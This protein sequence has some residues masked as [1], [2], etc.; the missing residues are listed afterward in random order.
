MSQH[1]NEAVVAM[2]LRYEAHMAELEAR[3]MAV[4]GITAELRDLTGRIDAL[5]AHLR[6]GPVD[7]TER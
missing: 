5:L 4:E 1:T 3:L 7:T 2:L 6:G